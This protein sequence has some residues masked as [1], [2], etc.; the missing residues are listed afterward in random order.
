MRM[1]FLIVAAMVLLPFA[2]RGQEP[3]AP[4]AGEPAPGMEQPMAPAPAEPAAPAPKR[5][6]KSKKSKKAS[7][8]KKHKKHKKHS[9]Y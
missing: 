2:S 1:K 4:P 8:G 3:T 9:Q 5:H 7:K 6:K